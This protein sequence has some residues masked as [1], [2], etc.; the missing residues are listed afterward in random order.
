MHK[1]WHISGSTRLYLVETDSPS[2]LR[3]PP[4]AH[5]LGFRVD[6]RSSVDEFQDHLISLMVCLDASPPQSGA[7]PARYTLSY[8][9][10]SSTLLRNCKSIIPISE[11]M[12]S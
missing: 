9:Y 12:V 8:K 6:G 4:S 10:I 11:E 7:R 3:R 2:V 5:I 1:G